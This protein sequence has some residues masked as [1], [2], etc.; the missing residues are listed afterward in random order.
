M[1]EGLTEEERE[2]LLAEQMKK[3]SSEAKLR[4]LGLTDSGITVVTG[5]FVA[6]NSEV[7]VNIQNTSGFDPEKLFSAL[8]EYRKAQREK[9][10]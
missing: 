6:L 8:A 7:A 1:L 3:L 4:V 10:T 9:G 5:S 2:S